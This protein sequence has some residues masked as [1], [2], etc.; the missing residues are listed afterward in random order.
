V[1]FTVDPFDIVGALLPWRTVRVELGAALTELTLEVVGPAQGSL[2]LLTL[3]V[4]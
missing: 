1:R 4:D 3:G 2:Q